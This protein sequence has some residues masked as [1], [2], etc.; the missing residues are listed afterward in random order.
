M[1]SLILALL[2]GIPSI[3]VLFY[4]RKLY[5]KNKDR[6]N[7]NLLLTSN[8]NSPIYIQH[9]ITN[10][11]EFSDTDTNK[12]YAVDSSSSIV[13]DL[14][15]IIPIDG[16]INNS[17]ITDEK[18]YRSSLSTID[19]SKSLTMTM[20]NN[21]SNEENDWVKKYTESLKQ[22]DNLSFTNISNC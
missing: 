1:N 2:V 9:N 16:D 3:M 14:S 11:E 20:I 17:Y 13:D 8:I 22:R 4:I 18:S 12:S 10:Y 15:Y 21:L 19:D 6:K 7:N 5:K